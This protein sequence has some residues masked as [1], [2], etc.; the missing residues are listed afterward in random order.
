MVP[1]LQGFGGLMDSNFPGLTAWAATSKAFG[2]QIQRA[3]ANETMLLALKSR[4]PGLKDLK[5]SAH[6]FLNAFIDYQ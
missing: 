4:G 3:W 1:P 6:K 5:L 2:P